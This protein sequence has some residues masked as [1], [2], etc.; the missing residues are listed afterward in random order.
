M[1]S[2]VIVL[3]IA[4]VFSAPF[5]FNS[6][7]APGI[8]DPSPVA[9]WLTN[10]FEPYV[11]AMYLRHGYAFFAPDPG[12][13][14]LFRVRLEFDDGRE[15][16][17]LTFPDRERNRPR[18]LYHRHFMLSERLAQ[19]YV[20]AVAPRD[21]AGD[22]LRLVEWRRNREAYEEY[23]SKLHDSFAAHLRHAYGADRVV[24]Q[25]LEHRLLTPD[26]VTERREIRDPSLLEVHP[27]DVPREQLP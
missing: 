7:P 16:R 8:T 5:T 20:P 10:W 24:I 9:L 22:P 17:E 3:H 1:L 12:P 21:I 18:L 6:N 13:S 19:G 23:Y 2:V 27:E 15:P 25:R 26:E 4:A 14:H 11:D